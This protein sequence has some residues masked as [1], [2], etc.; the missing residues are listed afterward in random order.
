VQLDEL[1]A[2]ALKHDQAAAELAKTIKQMGM[3][4]SPVVQG[5]W[6]YHA[7]LQELAK[8]ARAERSRLKPGAQ[9]ALE[10]EPALDN[11]KLQLQKAK[12]RL[13]DEGQVEELKEKLAR[14]SK[15]VEDTKLLVGKLQVDVQG[16]HDEL[17]T[18]ADLDS[19]E[20]PAPAGDSSDEDDDME[21]EDHATAHLADLLASPTKRH[22]DDEL[23]DEGGWPAEEESKSGAKRD[24][25]RSPPS[26]FAGGVQRP[27]WAARLLGRGWGRVVV[28]DWRARAVG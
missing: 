3:D 5:L 10:K 21:A 11:K 25:T 17:G 12:A 13:V 9:V 1:K 18:R 8:K 4:N 16:L 20:P 27:F 15:Q 14:L 23:H 7:S 28:W 2:T 19:D 26:S 22:Q 24:R 6:A